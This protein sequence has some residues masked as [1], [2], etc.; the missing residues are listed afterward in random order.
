MH[1]TA[2]NSTSFKGNFRLGEKM[3]PEVNLIFK[4]L[5]LYDL[6]QCLSLYVEDPAE[7]IIRT[8]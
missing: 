2:R 3:I 6:A 5:N 7:H 4:T 1:E 8:E